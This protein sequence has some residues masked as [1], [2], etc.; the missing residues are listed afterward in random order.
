MAYYASD[1]NK[2]RDSGSEEYQPYELKDSL[3]AVNHKWLSK[4]NQTNEIQRKNEV[5]YIKEGFL[6]S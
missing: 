1:V 5:S 4:P 6:L 2:S 3:V